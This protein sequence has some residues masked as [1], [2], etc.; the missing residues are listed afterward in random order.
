MLNRWY[1]FANTDKTYTYERNGQEIKRPI[2]EKISFDDAVVDSFSLEPKNKVP[3]GQN[4]VGISNYFLD[5]WSHILGPNAAFTYIRYVRHIY[6]SS[7]EPIISLNKMATYIG[8][9][10]N[11]LKKYLS[12]LEHYGFVAIF[13]KDT[14]MKSKGKEMT[15]TLVR[16]K[17]RKAIPF[18][19]PDLVGRLPKELQDKHKKDILD[20]EKTSSIT[21]EE[22]R[23]VDEIFGITSAISTPYQNLTPESEDSST[24]CQN[25]IPGNEE[26]FTPCQNLIPENEETSTPCQDQIPENKEIPTPCQDLI[27][28]NKDEDI[29]TLSNF[30]IPPYQN[31]TPLEN[32]NITIG[33]DCIGLGDESLA[34]VFVDNGIDPQSSGAVKILD[35]TLAEGASSDQMDEAIQQLNQQLKNGVFIRNEFGWLRNKLR[36]I[37]AQE[38][39]HVQLQKSQV[40]RKKHAKK[41]NHREAPKKDKYEAFYL[42]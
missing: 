15:N 31:L 8:I 42:N 18:L 39:T 41:A 33:L 14:R 30:D 38:K 22:L 25:L 13:Y 12:D 5:Y 11:T 21:H 10:I 28:G 40:P 32:N 19:T 16:I 27:P 37:I 23:S 3:M 26:T 2:Q 1:R 6:T 4:F 36:E 34:K 17:V 24:P 9:S 7:Y 35:M 20:Y 29:H